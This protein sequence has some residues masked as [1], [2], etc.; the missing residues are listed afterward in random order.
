MKSILRG[1][2]HL[3]NATP[4]NDQNQQKIRVYLIVRFCLI[5]KG[6]VV[7]TF[8]QN[9]AEVNFP[10]DIVVVNTVEP[11]FSEHPC[12]W[13]QGRLFARVVNRRNV[14]DRPKLFIEE[15]ILDFYL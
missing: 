14:W 15:D 5:L 2:G 7:A 3:E 12:Q 10:M 8:C 4:D 6:A 9:E 1:P 13:D 11:L